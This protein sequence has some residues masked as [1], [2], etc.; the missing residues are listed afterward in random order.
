[1]SARSVSAPHR[2]SRLPCFTKQLLSAMFA[3][4]ANV[5][6]RTM[7][8]SAPGE[9]RG[10]RQKGTPNRNTVLLRDRLAA[11]GIEPADELVK[12][13]RAAQSSGELDLAADCWGKLAAFVY[14]KPRPVVIDP[15]GLIELEGRIAEVRTRSIM[16]EGLSPLLGLSDRL[17]R[18]KLREDERAA[19]VVSALPAPIV[20]TV[21]QNKKRTIR[22]NSG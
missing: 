12:I 13:A 2:V 9:R 17:A 8:G 22:T 1:M 6:K 11:E 18:A 19:S 21:I 4:E 7:R 14:P 15:E 16:K 20:S 5:A 10:G 3:I